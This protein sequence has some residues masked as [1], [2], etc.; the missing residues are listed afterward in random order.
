MQSESHTTSTQRNT[1]QAEKTHETEIRQE[2]GDPETIAEEK[3][4]HEE[5]A[6]HSPFDFFSTKNVLTAIGLFASMSSV[7]VGINALL[8]T[9]PEKEQEERKSPRK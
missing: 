6:T 9:E 8:E 1:H 7:V 2:G 4:E 3:K 5:T